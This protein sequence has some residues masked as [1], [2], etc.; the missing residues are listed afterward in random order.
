MMS[1]ERWATVLGLA[2]LTLAMLL[3]VPGVRV[4][5]ADEPEARTAQ[6]AS[7]ASATVAEQPPA[8]APPA[9]ARTGELPEMAPGQAMAQVPGT[10]VMILNG[11]GYNYGGAKNP[12]APPKALLELE[13]RTD[14]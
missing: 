5:A 11:N 9:A 1:R 3:T 13:A 4:V 7:P 2:C 6:P 10:Q 12:P 14:R 8:E